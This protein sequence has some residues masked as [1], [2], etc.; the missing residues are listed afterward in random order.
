MGLRIGLC[1]SFVHGESVMLKD[2]KGFWKLLAQCLN[3]HSLIFNVCSDI[4]ISQMNDTKH[5]TKQTKG[6]V[7][8]ILA[9]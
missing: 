8:I 6:H 5:T 7:H 4:K 9:I 3:K 1:D 2:I